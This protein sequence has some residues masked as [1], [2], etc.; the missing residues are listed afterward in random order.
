MKDIRKLLAEQ[1][2][3]VLPAESV[4]ENIKRELG[5]APEQEAAYAHGG[6]TVAAPRKKWLALAATA[7]AIVLCLAIILPIAL[8]GAGGPGSVGGGI[9]TIDTADEFYAYSAASVGS[10]LA[11]SQANDGAQTADGA[12]SGGMLIR[13]LSSRAA[14]G[15]ALTPE[16]Q[17][18]ADTVDEYLGLV[19][20]LLADGEI[21]YSAVQ[22]SQAEYGY[23]YRMTVTVR[24]LLGQ[25]FDYTMYYDKL[26]IG[27]ETEGD[28]VEEEYAIE[29]VLLVG[30]EQYPVLG[31]KET[32]NETDESE[33]SLQ[34]TAY[35]PGDTARRVPYLRMQQESETELDDKETEKFFRYTLF[36]EQGNEAETTSVEYSTEEE[37]REMELKMTVKRGGE[38]DELLFRRKGGN[39]NVLSAEA[40]IGGREYRFTVTIEKGKYRYEFSDGNRFDGDRFDRDDHDDD[41]D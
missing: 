19:E 3:K 9:G 6:T 18:I 41:D 20:N 2:D 13:T 32:E 30:D 5:F 38:K 8:R 39:N 34:F 24:D 22:L 17:E 40:T 7:L 12:A 35:R 14:S 28:E 37:E 23:P 1:S 31:E 26:L 36:D 29:G 27:S 10:I 4:K 16:E 15:N 33:L 25:P 21:E 11:S